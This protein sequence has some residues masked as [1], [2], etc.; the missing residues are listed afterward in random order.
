MV[1]HHRVNDHSGVV[2]PLAGCALIMPI[3][4]HFQVDCAGYGRQRDQHGMTLG[5]VLQPVRVLNQG[6]DW[7]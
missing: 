3:T 1:G 2:L 7:T 5:Q 4:L 6:G